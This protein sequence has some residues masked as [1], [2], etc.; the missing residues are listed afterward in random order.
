MEEYASERMIMQA[1]PPPDGTASERHQPQGE[2]SAT[3][4]AHPPLLAH[5]D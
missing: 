1:A 3:C 4:M 5:D 2:P